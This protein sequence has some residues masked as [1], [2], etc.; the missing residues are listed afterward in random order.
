MTMKM[1]NGL[2]GLKHYRLRAELSQQKLAD[3]LGVE[4]ATVT[5]WENG[6]SWPSA[7]LL[8]KI[9]VLLLCS[10]DDLYH[11][12]QVDDTEEKEVCP[13]RTSALISTEGTAELPA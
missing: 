4:R 8:P 1:I 5:M 10:I 6:R 12:P 13:C 11:G 7:A 3:A 2:Q 9:S